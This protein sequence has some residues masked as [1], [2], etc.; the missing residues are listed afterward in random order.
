MMG[1]ELNRH[2]TTAV[3]TDVNPL[4]QERTRLVLRRLGIEVVAGSASFERAA[5]LAEIYGCDLLVVGGGEDVD[6]SSVYRVLRKAH[7]VRPQ[8][9]S[10]TMVEDASTSMVEA[11]LAAGSFAVVARPAS[12]DELAA[13]VRGAL[14][15]RDNDSV[16]DAP[17]R[18]RLTRREIGILRIVA[19]GRSNREVA[20]LLWVSDQTVKFHLANIYKKL[21]VRNR[22]EASAWA[23]SRGLVQVDR[24]AV[25]EPMAA[26]R[27]W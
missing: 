27:Q 3:V 17:R 19:E 14:A 26:G 5:E 22:V 16:A 4:R 7:K 21:G 23:V 15:E 8:L 10:V 6:P 1:R 24:M 11:A 18:C 25:L 20:K 12:A 9:A 2:H 13:V